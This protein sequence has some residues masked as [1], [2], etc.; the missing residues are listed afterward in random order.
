[1]LHFARCTLQLHEK[2]ACCMLSCCTDACCVLHDSR[3]LDAHSAR[4]HGAGLAGLLVAAPCAV[5]YAMMHGNVSFEKYWWLS[6]MISLRTSVCAKPH[7]KWNGTYWLPSA[8]ILSPNIDTNSLSS[9]ADLKQPHRMHHAESTCDVQKTT[10]DV[11]KTTCDTDN[12]QQTTD[13]SHRATQPTFSSAADRK[14]PA[15][16]AT[17][18]D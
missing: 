10:C 16:A 12:V 4:R 11:Q 7:M 6:C 14:Q 1:M 2:G 13:N 9:A 3:P 17:W 18:R 15:G 5:S 8:R